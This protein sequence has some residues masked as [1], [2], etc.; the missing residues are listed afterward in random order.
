M[1]TA[2][3]PRDPSPSPHGGRCPG[4]GARYREGA[5]WCG[6]CLAP[7]ERVGTGVRE[8]D[9]P[10][11]APAPR[12]PSVPGPVV[13]APWERGRDWG[14]DT[15]TYPAVPAAPEPA[16]VPGAAALPGL[17]PA[18]GP[19]TGEAL[20]GPPRADGTGGSG[21]SG[22]GTTGP[23]TPGGRAAADPDPDASAL[24]DRMLA[25]LAAGEREDPLL[26]ERLAW[27]SSPS[28]RSARAVYGSFLMI[29]VIMMFMVVAGHFV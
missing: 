22:H 28:G 5:A 6:Q 10:A 19:G 29:L 4:C 27:M 18:L 7:L 8:G 17:P 14:G 11:G 25:E 20:P 13:D 21:P 24:A 1:D 3:G 9:R 12:P 2:S 23:G 15:A 26:P 16:A